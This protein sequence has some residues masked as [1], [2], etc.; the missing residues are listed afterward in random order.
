MI[1]VYKDDVLTDEDKARK[2]KVLK[3]N[4]L[5]YVMIKLVDSINRDY[6]LIKFDYYLQKK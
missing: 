1:N 6:C 4:Y 3:E 2:I 5:S